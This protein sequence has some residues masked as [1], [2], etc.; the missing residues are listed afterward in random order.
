[1][2]K[3]LDRPPVLRFLIMFFGLLA[4]ALGLAALAS[5][6]EPSNGTAASADGHRAE[7]VAEVRR[8]D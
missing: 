2:K 7:P 5:A 4:A 6:G 3:T 8:P 1:M